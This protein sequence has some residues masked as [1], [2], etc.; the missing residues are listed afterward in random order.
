MRDTG[1][2]ALVVG[3]MDQ[4]FQVGHLSANCIHGDA[5]HPLRY[6]VGDELGGQVRGGPN[7]QLAEL[8]EDLIDLAGRRGA[9]TGTSVEIPTITC[10]GGERDGRHGIPKG[11]E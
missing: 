9:V 7:T 5:E 8:D 1:H 6:I 4:G 10:K 3:I 11:K 2:E